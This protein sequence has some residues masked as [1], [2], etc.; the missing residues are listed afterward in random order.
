MT[1]YTIEIEIEDHDLWSAL[2]S[3]INPN[4]SSGTYMDLKDKL[5]DALEKQTDKY[6]LDMEIC[7]RLTFVDEQITWIDEMGYDVE[8]FLEDMGYEN[9]KELMSEY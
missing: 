7:G 6:E 2:E 3:K 9:V 8:E 5:L 1:K 4:V